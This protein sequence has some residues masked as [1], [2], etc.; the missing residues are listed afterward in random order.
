[1]SYEVIMFSVIWV[2]C[3]LIFISADRSVSSILL[4]ALLLPYLVFFPFLI[5]EVLDF[6]MA[7]SIKTFFVIIFQISVMWSVFSYIKVSKLKKSKTKDSV[8]SFKNENFIFIFLLFLTSIYFLLE[9][10]EILSA[11]SGIISLDFGNLRREHW[12]Q[13]GTESNPISSIGRS[14]A[15]ILAI[16][17]YFFYRHNRK[18]KLLFSL[19]AFFFIFLETLSAGG[20]GNI[21]YIFSCVLWSFFLFMWLDG[22]TFF[23]SLP[24]TVYVVIGII[25]F[26]GAVVFPTTR[27]TSYIGNYDKYLSFRHDVQISRWVYD[28][29][30]SETLALLAFS[31]Q[32]F[33]QPVVKM[34][35]HIENLNVDN[36]YYLGQFNFRP[37]KTEN[38]RE[39]L[40][41]SIASQGYSAVNPWGTAARDIIIDFGYL[42]G[43]IFLFFLSCILKFGTNLW[44]NKQSMLRTSLASICIM[45]SFMMYFTSAIR[46]T[47]LM[48]SLVLVFILLILENI[49]FKK[50]LKYM[51]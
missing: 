41:D 25:F 14:A 28:S 22:K 36:Y 32:Y 12:A 10:S 4:K 48:N 38:V 49:S 51:D 27:N 20:R 45:F 43:I 6:N 34:T 13:A 11:L 24:R 33:V 39:K 3:F 19:A 31:S 7:I 46:V 1:M 21:F 35:D 17:S 30:Y 44:E 2:Y 42:G 47:L 37:L 50:L 40:E 15:F 26:L 16:N 8:S 5:I 29:R 9:L 18:I 23:K